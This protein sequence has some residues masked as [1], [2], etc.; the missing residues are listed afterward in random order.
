VLAP[1][2]ALALIDDPASFDIVPFKR[3]CLSVHWEFMF[4][5]PVFQT[6]DMIEQHRLLA[7]V[8]A[9]VD[10]GVLKTTTGEHF[11]RIDAANLRRGHAAI[12]SGTSIGKIVLSGF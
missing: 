7:E 1:Q 5:R 6:P 10:A 11:G 8:S 3:K 9:L 4:A 12:E 2:G